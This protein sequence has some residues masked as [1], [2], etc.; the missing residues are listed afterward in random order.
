M[1]GLQR[2]ASKDLTFQ[3]FWMLPSQNFWSATLGNHSSIGKISEE[4]IFQ[5]SPTAKE[6]RL[7]KIKCPGGFR[8]MLVSSTGN[9]SASYTVL[10]NSLVTK[11][12]LMIEF[13]ACFL[14]MTSFGEG[15]FTGTKCGMELFSEPVC[16]L[17]MRLVTMMDTKVEE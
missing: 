7:V 14:R 2:Y 15:R 8:I 1:I 17:Q 9:R 12:I 13:H 3:Q 10:E 11:H 5:P 4:N 16:P 6:G